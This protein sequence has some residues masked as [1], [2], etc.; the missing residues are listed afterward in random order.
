M[1]AFLSVV[2]DAASRVN[3]LVNTVDI[4]VRWVHEAQNES[5]NEN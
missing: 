1:G 2:G 4:A 5:G 3:R